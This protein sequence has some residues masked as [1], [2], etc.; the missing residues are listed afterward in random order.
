MVFHDIGNCKFLHQVLP[1][2]INKSNITFCFSAEKWAQAANRPDL[3]KKT[4]DC[5]TKYY[6]CAEHFTND[7]F[8]DPPYNTRLKKTNHPLSIPIPTIFKCNL[9]KHFTHNQSVKQDPNKSRERRHK[10]NTESKR[11]VP[12]GVSLLNKI[13]KNNSIE[14]KILNSA[15]D[16][17]NNISSGQNMADYDQGEGYDV[18]LIIEDTQM[19]ETK[20]NVGTNAELDPLN[21]PVDIVHL[22]CRL[23]ASCFCTPDDLFHM[24]SDRQLEE[25]I[26][27]LMP[28]EVCFKNFQFLNNPS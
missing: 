17:L 21:S 5:I 19:D 13:M 6:L 27:R 24:F 20:N 11:P 25:R 9:P 8:I 23:C 2:A 18:D 12:A 4:L 26:H 7:C 15:N 1:R 28:G 16:D 22:T 10:A 14:I 3:L